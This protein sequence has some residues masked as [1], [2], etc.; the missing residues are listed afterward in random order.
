MSPVSWHNI[1]Y[2]ESAASM[3]KTNNQPDTVGDGM[4]KMRKFKIASPKSMA[5]GLFDQKKLDLGD[6]KKEGNLSRL[7]ND[8][9]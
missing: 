9:D 8:T 5:S 6:L 1:K 4:N 3:T 7:M 2:E